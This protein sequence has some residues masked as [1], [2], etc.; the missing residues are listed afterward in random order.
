[1]PEPRHPS[2]GISLCAHAALHTPQQHL[3][4]E[5]AT[6]MHAALTV[7]EPKVKVH[8]LYRLEVEKQSQPHPALR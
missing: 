6:S 7:I 5:K 1:M 2:R 3:G 8:E 4:R